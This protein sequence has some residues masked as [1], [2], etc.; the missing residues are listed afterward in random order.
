MIMAEIMKMIRDINIQIVET[1]QKHYEATKKTNKEMIINVMQNM[2]NVSYYE[3]IDDDEN[4]MPEGISKLT[5]KC[6]FGK[7]ITS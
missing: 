1:S 4:V 3:D 2:K 5:K 6:A 7:P